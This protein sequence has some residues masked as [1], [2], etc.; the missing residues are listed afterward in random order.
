[1]MPYKF[2]E[3]RSRSRLEYYGKILWCISLAFIGFLIGRVYGFHVYESVQI[4]E[5]RRLTAQIEYKGEHE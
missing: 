4:E 3:N 5:I 2:K 1:M